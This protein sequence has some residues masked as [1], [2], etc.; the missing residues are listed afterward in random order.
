MD[1]KKDI[2]VCITIDRVASRIFLFV[3]IIRCMFGIGSLE[4]VIGLL[5]CSG[6]FSIA[7]GL[8]RLRWPNSR[9]GD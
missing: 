1:G 6:L 3:A 9:K 5:I 8:E 2:D 7:D 4:I